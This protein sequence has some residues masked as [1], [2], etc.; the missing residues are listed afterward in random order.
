MFVILIVVGGRKVAQSTLIVI[1]LTR[2]QE[3]IGRPKQIQEIA[4]KGKRIGEI[5]EIVV[6]TKNNLITTIIQKDEEEKETEEIS[7]NGVSTVY[8][9]AYLRISLNG[10]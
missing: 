1:I 10:N 4:K 9:D 5:K 7:K 8:L 6:R 3:I 2:A